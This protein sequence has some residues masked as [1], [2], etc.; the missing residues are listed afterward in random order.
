[1]R[2]L[3]INREKRI[4]KKERELAKK[5]EMKIKLW[6]ILFILWALVHLVPLIFQGR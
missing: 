3:N 6:H 1:M 2:K 5:K 4:T